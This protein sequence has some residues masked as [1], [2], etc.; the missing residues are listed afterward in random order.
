M[1]CALLTHPSLLLQLER[2]YLVPSY[3]ADGVRYAPG[4]VFVDGHGCTLTS[5]TGATY[6]DWAA[7]IAVNALGHSDPGVAAALAAGSVRGV[8][9]LSNYFHSMPPLRLARD[10]VNS[11]RHFDKEFLGNSGTEAN[12]GALKFAKKHA[13]VA[14]QKAAGMPAT[15]FAGFG[16][17]AVPPTA[18]ATSGGWCS[19]WPQVAAPALAPLVRTQVIAFKNGFHG[20]SMGS[21][22]ATHKPTIRQPFG[23][24]PPDV[25]FARY[26]NA[27]DLEA[28]IGPSTLAVIVEPVQGEAGVVPADP[29]FMKAVRAACTAT[30]ALMIVDEVQ[31]GL[32]RTGRLWA[33]EAYDAAPDMMTL[34]KPLAGGLPIGVVMVTDAVAA[35]ITPGD[36]GSTFGGNPL[37][38]GVA[39]HVLA[40]VMAPGFLEHSVAR[41]RQLAAG[42]RALAAKYP[43]H[44]KEVRSP[45]D[46]GLFIGV[47]LT[48]PP[49]PLVQ[50][51]LKQ[52]LVVITGGDSSLRICPPL[53]I[54]EAEVAH[55]VAC[56]GR[57]MDELW[58]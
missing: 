20:R 49:K 57:A 14:A 18:C 58:G 44:I 31:C 9:H 26:N 51:A 47:E 28:R 12:E 43:R 33:H 16:C 29:A 46:G 41:G 13:L 45:L 32:G 53:V 36:H 52:G 48:V 34:A 23:P 56:L 24:F 50:A 42:M 21:L 2:T 5:S 7:G 35:A 40:R 19:C 22:A 3:N 54:T 1:P 6:L 4:L 30:G 10:L 15:P 55:G 37:V 39:E 8:Q 27:S 38:A 25:S 17:K 11:T